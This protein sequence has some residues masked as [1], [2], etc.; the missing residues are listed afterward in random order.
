M[1]SFTFC[2][3]VSGCRQ[4]FISRWGKRAERAEQL[5]AVLRLM[6]GVRGTFVFRFGNGDHS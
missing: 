6:G 5:Q 3:G 4:S 1:M 2:S